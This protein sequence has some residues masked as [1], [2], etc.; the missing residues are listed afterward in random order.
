MYPDIASALA[1]TR[2]DDL[3][4]QAQQQ[5][6]VALA[7]AAAKASARDAA[8][9]HARVLRRHEPQVGQWLRGLRHRHGTA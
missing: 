9:W 1:R 7:R 6:L 2:T 4:K 8:P 5:R 3:I